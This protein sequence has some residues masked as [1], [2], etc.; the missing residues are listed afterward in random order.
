[1]QSYKNPAAQWLGSPNFTLDRNGHDMSPPS[2]IVMHTMVGTI[3]SANGRFQQASQQASAHY[4][5]GLNGSLVQWVDEK[6]A[7]W[8]AGNFTV[9]LDSI[10]IEHEDDGNYNSPRTP[11]LKKASA[12]LI[13]ELCN[14]YGIKCDRSVIRLHKEVSDNPTA[15]PDS[16]EVDEIVGMAQA[17]LGGSVHTIDELYELMTKVPQNNGESY[18]ADVYSSLLGVLDRLKA[19]IAALPAASPAPDVTA[20]TQ[21]VDA[22]SAA[23]V[24]IETALKAA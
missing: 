18:L 6:D 24:R 7:A 11:E 8:H 21:K 14:H 23:V 9:N 13:A 3:G 17:L 10:G 1:M 16:L 2:Y 4:G 5:I 19:Q 15:C 20:L 22:L 12:R